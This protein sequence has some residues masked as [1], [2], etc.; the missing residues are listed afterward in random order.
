[1]ASDV[2]H[3]EIGTW[4]RA[5]QIRDSHKYARD[6]DDAQRKDPDCRHCVVNYHA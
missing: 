2:I 6:R 3:G 5:N 1:M 4:I